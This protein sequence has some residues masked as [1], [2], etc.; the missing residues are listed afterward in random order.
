[1]VSAATIE[2][3]LVSDPVAHHPVLLHQ[4]LEL[5]APRVGDVVVDATLGAGGHTEALLEAVGS[6]GRVIGVDRDPHAL[7][8]A[9]KRL[10]CFGES[11]VALHGNHGDL[12][13]LLGEIGIERIDRVLFDLGLSSMQID[14]PGRGFSFREDGPLDMRMDPRG[15]RT[16]RLLLAT[17]DEGELREILWRF[18]EERRAR[19]IARAIVREREARPIE[20]TLQL[21]GLVERTLGPRARRFRIHPATRTF[22]ALRIA[23]NDEIDGL[24]RVVEDGVDLLRSGGRLAVIA[25]HSLEDRAIKHTLRS[26]VDRCTCP[27]GLPVCGCGR[28]SLIR[29]VTARPVRPAAD[30]IERNARARSAKLRVAEKL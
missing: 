28:E 26:L 10:A 4:T 1:M 11:F 20:R 25:F 12:R 19:A 21:A 6:K 30:E 5:L 22:Q 23:V 2:E 18:G 13:Q 7:E 8:I 17:L 27:R 29:V 14:D 16:A 24:G 15:E 9:G 3:P